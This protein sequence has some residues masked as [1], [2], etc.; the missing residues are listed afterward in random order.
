MVVS[1]RESR[2]KRRIR[3]TQV[4]F[5]A[6]LLLG[7]LSLGSHANAAT[8]QKHYFGHDAVQDQYGVIAPWYKGQNG[9]FDFRVR[10]AAET[11][12]RYPWAK[13]DGAVMAA[14]EY[15]FNGQWNI[16]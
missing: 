2:S 3:P 10:I 5:S 4:L 6:T 9:Q 12:K 14:P 8:V 1:K 11:L 13:R 16:D 7:F 15:V